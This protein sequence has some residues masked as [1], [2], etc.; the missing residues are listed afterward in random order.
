MPTHHGGE[1]QVMIN[2]RRSLYKTSAPERRF[3]GSIVSTVTHLHP[4]DPEPRGSGVGL[5]S[6]LVEYLYSI[7][8]LHLGIAYRSSL[9]LGLVYSVH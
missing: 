2:S 6:I 9:D 3:I 5:A 4:F 1:E 7:G 8:I